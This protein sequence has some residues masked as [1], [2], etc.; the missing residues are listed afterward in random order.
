VLCGCSRGVLAEKHPGDPQTVKLLA[1]GGYGGSGGQPSPSEMVNNV[2]FVDSLPVQASKFNI[3]NN[4]G[5]FASE[6]MNGKKRYSWEKEIA[7]EV[8]IWK[9]LEFEKPIEWMIRINVSANLSADWFD[10]AAWDNILHNLML[11]SR[12]AKETGAVGFNLDN[13]Q[14]G[15]KPFCYGAQQDRLVRS[16]DEC[17]KQV[18]KRGRGFAEA[19]TSHLPDAKLMFLYGNSLLA[20][21]DGFK[22]PLEARTM[23]LWPAFLDG[24]MDASE[25]AEFIDGHENY[26]IRTFEEFRNARELVKVKGA[27][28]SQDPKRYKKRI[29]AAFSVWLRNIK[30]G[31]E[32]TIDT[33]D[34]TNNFFTPEELKHSLHYAML[35]SDQ[36]V[37]LYAFPWRKLPKEYMQAIKDCRQTVPID[38]K[39]ADRAGQGNP[40]GYGSRG[41]PSAKGRADCNDEIVFAAVRKVYKEIYDFPKKWTFRLDPENKG[42]KEKWYKRYD[43]LGWMDIEIGEWWEPQLQAPY[44]GYAWYCVVFDVPESWKGKK[45]L[46]AFGAVDEEAW[47]WLNGKKAGEHAFG[48]NGWCDAFEMD[49]TKCVKAG[50][51]NTMVVRVRN[52]GGMGGIWKGV[53]IF[54]DK[55]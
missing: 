46:L 40:L 24:M 28:F 25:T 49:I 1:H 18:R 39:F 15:Y 26:G 9:Q 27:F 19:L 50:Q 41:F 47:V 51:K 35:N 17:R 2:E 43:E 13:E 20:R 32:G 5:Y 34:F 31:R 52:T 36:Y 55:D 4:G 44:L 48:P 12:A 11:V 45:L 3:T 22:Q 10:D 16:F 14:Y 54:T 53:K 21:G 29:Q 6:C 8:E 7:P 30:V 37:W 38:F 33:E 42:V 23:G